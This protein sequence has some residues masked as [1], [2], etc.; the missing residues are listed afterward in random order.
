VATAT[1]RRRWQASTFRRLV[2]INVF[3]ETRLCIVHGFDR[4][5]KRRSLGSRIVIGLIGRLTLHVSRL[6][7]AMRLAWLNAALVAVACLGVALGAS[8]HGAMGVVAVLTAA[9]VCGVCANVALLLAT[10]WHGTPNGVVGSLAGS[11]V[12]MLPPLFVGFTLNQQQGDL[13]R[14][15]VFGWIVAFYLTALMVKT[16]LVAP[17]STGGGAATHKTSEAGA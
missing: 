17:V 1:D 10:R 5:L 4:R 15:G 9:L 7:T 6:S 2:E 16:L 14:A 13:A 11:L 3:S 8:R 12:G